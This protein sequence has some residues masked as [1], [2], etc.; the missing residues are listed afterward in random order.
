MGDQA[1]P[2]TS[3]TP[4]QIDTVVAILVAAFFNDPL[5]G[6]AFPDDTRRREQHGRVWRYFVHGAMRYPWVW[7]AGGSVATS[8]WI[9]PGGSEL[10]DEQVESFEP[11]LVELLGSGA[12]RV[13]D[14][15]EALDGVHPHSEPHYYLS[16]L[17]TDPGHLGHGYG[18][19]LLA[20]N[21]RMIDSE[22]MPAYLEA[23]NAG[24]VPIYARLGF[25]VVTSVQPRG[26][27]PEVFTMWREPR[28]G[29]GGAP[30]AS[31]IPGLGES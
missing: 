8:V 4:D 17:A 7:L 15:Y 31:A 22:G 23:S 19:G 10:S 21:L 6:W 25:E 13:L 14:A 26:G 28:L 5:W 20:D 1:G 30:D 9:P 16:L 24:N 11:M 27:G 12:A 3:V 29:S 2:P 18:V